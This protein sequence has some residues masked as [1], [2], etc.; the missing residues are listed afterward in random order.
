MSSKKKVLWKLG[1]PWTDEELR[2][3][4]PVPAPDAN[5]YSRGVLTVVAGSKKY[6]GAACLASRAG[7]RMGAGYTEVVTC[8][9]AADLILASYPSIVVHDVG[10]W[11][12]S[13]MR[14]DKKKSRHAVC[15]GPGFEA[16]DKRS[17]QLVLRVLKKAKCPVLVDG[18]G[19]SAFGSK[20]VLKALAKRQ[21]RGLATIITPHAG[22]ARR[23]GEGLGAKQKAPEQLSAVLA[24]A[25][26]AIVVMKGPDT[27]VS[28]GKQTYP[29]YEGTP[30][31]AKAGTGD[32]LAGMIAALLAQ[33]VDP[34]SAAVL[35]ATL[36]A[37][38]GA[39]AAQSCTAIGVAP[40]DV[41]EAIPA[42]INSLTQSD[43]A[44]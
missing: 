1:Q 7:Q 40:E 28:T 16:G 27:Y 3:A 8:K 39:I 11:D 2:S 18:G 34:V 21:E 12:V 41:I 26:G 22:E 32:V 43:P 23:M 30:A 17:E 36:H 4:L 25:T 20:E 9:R 6:P 10:K 19:L 44:E 35:G 24:M 38:A 37:R 42:A 5:K 29:I 31:L 14:D 13:D 33:D 15:I